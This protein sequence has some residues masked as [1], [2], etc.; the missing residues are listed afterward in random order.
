MTLL[1]PLR[2][3]HRAAR[4]LH[5]GSLEDR[6]RGGAAAELVQR[7][8]SLDRRCG[9]HAAQARWRAQDQKRRSPRDQNTSSSCASHML[10]IESRRSR[11]RA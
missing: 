7:S 4:A 1:R 3:P 11:P 9:L 5:G 8:G 10:G 2:S 6:A